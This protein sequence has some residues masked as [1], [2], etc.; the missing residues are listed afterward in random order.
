MG[1][2]VAPVI[3]AKFDCQAILWGEGVGAEKV[4]VGD[5][6]DGEKISAFVEDDDLRAAAPSAIGVGVIG[7]RDLSSQAA[8]GC[9]PGGGRG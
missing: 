9:Q 2:I 4:A 7:E 8:C 1:W 5:A 6:L 3:P